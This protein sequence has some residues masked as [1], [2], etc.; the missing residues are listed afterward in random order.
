[1]FFINPDFISTKD[2]HDEKDTRALG[3]IPQQRGEHIT[4][5]ENYDLGT[6]LLPD[7]LS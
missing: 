1:L 4:K 3:L 2:I 7:I 6:T 5:K